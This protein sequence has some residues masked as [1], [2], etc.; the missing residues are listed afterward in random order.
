MT[1]GVKIGLSI[2]A[3]AIASILFSSM[4]VADRSLPV[5]YDA[6]RSTTG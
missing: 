2:I 5:E 4:Y 6:S 3:I 1:L